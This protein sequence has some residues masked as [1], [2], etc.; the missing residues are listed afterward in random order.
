[1][2]RH[3]GETQQPANMSQRLPRARRAESLAIWAWFAAAIGIE[4]LL[5]SYVPRT[6]HGRL[7]YGGST[8]ALAVVA[9]L[10]TLVI[11]KVPVGP[12]GFVLACV[13]LLLIVP[14]VLG[15]VVLVAGL[16]GVAGYHVAVFVAVLLGLCLWALLFLPLAALVG[17]VTAHS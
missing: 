6:P 17:R 5:R 9:I 10:L 1:M 12:V 8:F 7:V 4:V 14:S 13:D 11:S 3:D 16:F 2:S 15:S